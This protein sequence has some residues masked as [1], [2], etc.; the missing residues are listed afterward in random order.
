[1]VSIGEPY[2][3]LPFVR[4]GG[5]ILLRLHGWPRVETV[6]KAVDA[7]EVLGVDP[8]DVAPDHWRHI[9]NRLSVNERFR[10]YTV[11]QHRVWLRRRGVSP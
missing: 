7:I 11:Q 10:A 5:E 8:A 3:T 6:L 9:H 4:P 2:Q 1:M